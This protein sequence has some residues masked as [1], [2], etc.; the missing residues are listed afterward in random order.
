MSLKGNKSSSACFK[1]VFWFRVLGFHNDLSRLSLHMVVEGHHQL[2]I[3]VAVEGAMV[4]HAVLN[5]EVCIYSSVC[6][7]YDVST[8][9]D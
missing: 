1:F 2:V 5:I 7:L 9:A 3:A 4:H 8:P 6:L